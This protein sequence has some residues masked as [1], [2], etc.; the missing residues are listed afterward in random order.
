MCCVHMML[1]STVFCICFETE[2]GSKWGWTLH[3]RFALTL[4]T[5]MW[6]QCF[7]V[8]LLWD[9]QVPQERDVGL[10]RAK[11]SWAV[12]VPVFL[13][14]CVPLS[15]SLCLCPCA[16]SLCLWVRIHVPMPCLQAPLAVRDCPGGSARLALSKQELQG[17]WGCHC[18]VTSPSC[19]C[20]CCLSQVVQC[21]QHLGH[22][23]AL[24]PMSPEPVCPGVQ[25]ME[26]VPW[27]QSMAYVPWSQSLACVPP[28]PACVPQNPAHVP[29]SLCA[30][31]PSLCAPES[32]YPRT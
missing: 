26:S 19:P 9:L 18:Q 4:C 30:P 32:M 24:W 13:F 25:G 20:P 14:P 28:S 11:G 10:E 6:G 15:L 17:C 1:C 23:G 22:G 16:M 27:T 7:P 31:E 21:Q 29:Q 8:C 2:L 12:P 5:S 3:M